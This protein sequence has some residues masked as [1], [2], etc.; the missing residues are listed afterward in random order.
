MKPAIVI[1]SRS[2]SSRIPHKPFQKVAGKYLLDHLIEQLVP[3]DIPI[4]IAI[5]DCDESKYVALASNDIK[6]DS[7]PLNSPLHRT[8]GCL[9]GTGIKTIIRITHDKIFI[10]TD[11]LKEALEVFSKGGLDYLYSSHLIDGTGFEIFSR[12]LL[13]QTC[14]FFQG[15][16]IEHLSYALKTCCP[17]DLQLNFI[18]KDGILRDYRNI[19]LLIDF[20]EDLELIRALY[21]LSKNTSPNLNSILQTFRENPHLRWINKQ[22]LITVYTCA[23]NAEKFIP[24]C[25]ESVVSQTIFPN[26]EYIVIDDCSTDNTYKR[27][28]S[29]K[30]FINGKIKLRR[31][32]F[33]LGLSSSSNVALNMA[34]GKYI[35]RLDADDALLFPFT[36]EKMVR[37]A[38]KEN[39]EALYPSYLDHKTKALRDGKGTHHV[40]GCLFLTK[41]IRNIQFTDNLR[42][43]EGLDLF[44]RAKD[45]MK[46]GYYDEFPVFFYNDSPDSMSKTNQE[47]REKIRIMI[48]EGKKGHDLIGVAV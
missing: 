39:I 8:Q 4:I 9:Y 25:I 5:P 35:M 24:W 7:S 37:K 19:R 36:L 2:N 29:S 46:I 16:Y 34:R 28:L 13:D 48:G 18:P 33:N 31:N 14:N 30:F 38:S 41:A 11:S 47:Y 42:G 20:E 1:C 23:Y 32:E 43:W 44:E 45:Q 10:D 26:I 17:P 6:I 15:Q 3:L 27:L 12:S 22:P 40:G 21:S